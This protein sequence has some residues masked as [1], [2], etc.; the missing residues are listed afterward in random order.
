[1]SVERQTKGPLDGLT[2]LDFSRVLAG[3]FATVLL[4]DLGARVI[5]IEPPAGDDY[6]HIGPFKGKESMLFAFANRGKESIVLDLKKPD[7]LAFALDLAGHAD[8]AVE[9]FRP[10]VA[11]KLGIG[12]GALRARNPRLIYASIS[13]FGQTS[14]MRERPAYDL[15]VQALTGLMSI[16]GEPDGP[17]TMLGE[18][19]GDLTAGLFGSWAIL[20]ALHQR[21]RTGAG[22]HVDLAMFDALL[23]MM[24][25]ATCRYVTT[26]KVPERVGNRHALSA[27]F[28]VFR[29]GDG[30]VVVAVLNEK[31]FEQFC[32]VI[33]RND[34]LSDPRFRSDSERTAH[35]HLLRSAFEQWSA[36]KSTQ[37]VVALLMAAGVPSAAIADVA[38]A[39]ESE[40]SRLR[41]LFRSATLAEDT[42]RVPEQPAV[43]STMQRGAPTHVPAL[44]EHGAGIRAG[45]REAATERQSDVPDGSKRA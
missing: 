34:L 24:P 11:D 32:G 23:S 1:M 26:G 6:R 40:H 5:K 38:T 41:S 7:D 9:N 29:S 15:I 19:F 21:E 36:S 3:P 28:G 27:P 8:I 31:L 43:F 4:A 10:G 39:V 17:P 13:G 44:G 30:H 25:T 33:G 37:D 20:A 45:L 16:T 22:C 14:P 12:A 2:V 35:E 18:A 42:A